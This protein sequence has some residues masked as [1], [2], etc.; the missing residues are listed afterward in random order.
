M[1]YFKH[2]YYPIPEQWGVLGLPKNQKAGTALRNYLPNTPVLLAQA[3]SA[4][5][6][7]R[8]KIFAVCT[9]KSDIEDG[10]TNKY[11]NPEVIVTEF[12]LRL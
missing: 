2:C 7:L 9:L 1:V 3:Q 4:M 11:G 6:D 10:L 8:G 5:G 12:W